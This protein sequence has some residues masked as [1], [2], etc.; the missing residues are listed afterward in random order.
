MEDQASLSAVIHG[1]VQGV[2]FRWAVLQ[3]AEEL[4]ITGYV[5]NRPDGT[6]EVV[7]EGGPAELDELEKFLHSGPRW[8][9]VSQVEVER[10]R[11]SG[12]F[13]RF[14]TK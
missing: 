2:G 12:R 7:A 3:R 9:E 4:G 10:G 5:S 1:M 6:V 11:A 13:S 8:A 14:V